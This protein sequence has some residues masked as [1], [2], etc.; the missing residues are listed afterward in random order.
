[1]RISGLRKAYLDVATALYLTCFSSA[2]GRILCYRNVTNV[3]CWCELDSR[4]FGLRK[5][6]FIILVCV[7]SCCH[8]QLFVAPRTVAHHTHLS[9]GFS[10]QEYWSGVPL[11]PPGVLSAFLSRACCASFNPTRTRMQKEMKQWQQQ[12]IIMEAAKD[13]RVLD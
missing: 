3:S 2:K 9:M 13:Y 5:D 12:R 6:G 8:V 4:R 11:P 1:M 10:R 7:L